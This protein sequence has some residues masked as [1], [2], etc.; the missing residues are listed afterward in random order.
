MTFTV[1]LSHADRFQGSSASLNWF[2]TDQTTAITLLLRQLHVVGCSRVMITN[3]HL[4]RLCG[5]ENVRLLHD[6]SLIEKKAADESASQF[7]GRIQT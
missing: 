1:L 3:L 5:S 4:R 2:V 7:C 6:W